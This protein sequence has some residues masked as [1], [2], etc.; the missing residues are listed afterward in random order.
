MRIERVPR[1]QMSN[2][3]KPN[4]T[5][6]RTDKCTLE[7]ITDSSP[8]VRLKEYMAQDPSLATIRRHTD[9]DGYQWEDGL[10]SDTDLTSGVNRTDN[11]VCLNSLGRSA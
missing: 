11:C 3:Q 1:K 5:C 8:R 10:Y 7:Q 4:S 6:T 9:T 2:R